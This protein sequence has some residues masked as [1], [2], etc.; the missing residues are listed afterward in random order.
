MIE[1]ILT[2]DQKREIIYKNG[3]TTENILAILLELQSASPEGYVEPQ[4][5]ALVARELGL[6]ETR[7]YEIASYYAM[8]K[9]RPQ[10][11]YVLEI[12]N[13][14][15]CRFSKSDKVVHMLQR[16]L[17]VGVGESTP[18]GLF[19]LHY[20]PCVGA[21]DVGP[22]IKIGDVVY[23]SLDEEKVRNIIGHLRAGQ[24][25]VQEGGRS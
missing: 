19:A 16:E 13:S 10:A 22:V 14:S 12:C 7:V 24:T 3:G 9:V 5:T 4:T 23:G 20:T 8:L 25:P 11:R 18:D 1:R 6:T 17:G 2:D 15:P 21:C